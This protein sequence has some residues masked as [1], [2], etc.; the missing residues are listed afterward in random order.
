MKAV[1]IYVA[2]ALLKR[3]VP[4]PECS[5]MLRS[6][7]AGSGEQKCQKLFWVDGV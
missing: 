7:V 4:S 5:W 6:G 2:V 3:N 1:W